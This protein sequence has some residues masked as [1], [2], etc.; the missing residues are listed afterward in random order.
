M[1]ST[2]LS[3]HAP[4]GANEMIE[5]FPIGRKLAFDQKRGRLWAVCTVCRQ[6]NLAALDERWE[7]IEEAARHYRATRLRAST[8]NIGLARLA[9]GTELIQIG[10]P[11]RPEFAAWR[12]GERF[13]AR[14][15]IRGPAAAVVGGAAMIFKKVPA[16]FLFQLGQIAIVPAVAIGSVVGVSHYIRT[17]RDVGRVPLASG[18]WGRLT[19]AHIEQLRIEPDRESPQ[20][21]RL[22]VKHSPVGDKPRRFHGSDPSRLFTGEE[23]TRIAAQLLPRVNRTGGRRS[24]VAEAVAVLERA[25]DPDAVFRMAAEQ[26]NAQLPRAKFKK[27]YAMDAR[28]PEADMRNAIV[29]SSVSAPYRLA[30]EMAAHEDQERRLMQ[31]E[32][33]SIEDQWREAEEIAAIADELTLPPSILRQLEKFRVR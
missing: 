30:A 5:H 1:Y 17:R 9:D 27:W 23:A 32:L 3:C 19:Q 14:W 33:K 11:Q 26:G 12:Y 2:C 13:A 24:A 31:G 18:R 28:D 20:G 8:D 7:A 21:W 15:R 4:L 22:R 25:G 6:W 16:Y 29:L 10:E